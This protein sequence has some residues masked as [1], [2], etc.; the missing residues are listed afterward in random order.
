M[1]RR[2][3]CHN[4]CMSCSGQD[5]AYNS[6][7]KSHI[8]GCHILRFEYYFGWREEVRCLSSMVLWMK[9]W[10]PV[11]T[12]LSRSEL[13][14]TG[15]VRCEIQCDFAVAKAKKLESWWHTRTKKWLVPRTCVRAGFYFVSL[16]TLPRSKLWVICADYFICCENDSRSLLAGR[17]IMW[18]SNNWCSN[19]KNVLKSVKFN[20]RVL[21]GNCTVTSCASHTFLQPSYQVHHKHRKLPT[22]APRCRR[23]RKQ[24]RIFWLSF[25]Q[26]QSQSSNLFSSH[27]VLLH[28]TSAGLAAFWTLLQ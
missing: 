24:D 15:M 10:S 23:V 4:T 27:V 28:G 16:S 1:F 19:T 5:A 3:K 11:P 13:A 6:N 2:L 21:L 17:F 8:Q 12:V 9:M 7:Q 26:N 20:S 18:K 25:P 14:L 22:I